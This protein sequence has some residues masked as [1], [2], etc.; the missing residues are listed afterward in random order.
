M[1]KYLFLIFLSSQIFAQEY[2]EY[3]VGTSIELIIPNFS[4]ALGES[5]NSSFFSLGTSL[6]FGRKFSDILSIEIQQL[7]AL[8]VEVDID[9]SDQ[10]GNI[11][12]LMTT[13]APKFY[14]SMPILPNP[15]LF[16]ALFRFGIIYLSGTKFTGNHRDG[17]STVLIPAIGFD[18][19]LENLFTLYGEISVIR[20]SATAEGFNMYSFAGGVRVN[21]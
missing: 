9:N 19:P 10:E 5:Y 16:Y 11:S 12:A 6:Q 15:F 13:I 17:F 14:I 3:Y 4:T 7:F 20:P 8:G 18:Y 1:K 2:D 21:F